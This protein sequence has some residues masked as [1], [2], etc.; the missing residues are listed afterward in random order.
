MALGRGFLLGMRAVEVTRGFIR[1][2][3]V[4]FFQFKAFGPLGFFQVLAFFGIWEKVDASLD[5][6]KTRA[7]VRS[8][9]FWSAR[10]LR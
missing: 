5:P 6:Q 2:R 10:V 3:V 4:H 8:R 7:N 1:L 9:W